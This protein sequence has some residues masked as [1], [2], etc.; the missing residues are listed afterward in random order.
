MWLET[1][2]TRLSHTRAPTFERRLNLSQPLQ[3]GLIAVVHT[4]DTVAAQFFH[5]S[6]SAHNRAVGSS[7]R[8]NAYATDRL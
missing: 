7:G 4:H 5:L 8:N 3:R 2:H 6:S 1:W